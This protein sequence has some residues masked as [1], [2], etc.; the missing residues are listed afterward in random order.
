MRADGI[1]REV[2]CDVEREIHRARLGAVCAA[3]TALIHGGRIGLS[4][5][6]R[7]IG[8][9]S[10]KHGI[11]RIDRLLG[12][13]ALVAELE[14]IYAAIAR[15]V[16]RSVER[17]VI[18]L[19]WTESGHDMYS[20]TAAV[21]LHGR[22][23]TIYSVT[24]PRSQYTA[25]LVENAFLEKLRTFLRSNCRPILVGDAGF[26]TP[27][28]RR[29]Q[30]MGWDFVARVRGRTLVKRVD[31]GAWQ[32]WKH[33]STGSSNRP[34]SLGTYCIARQ[35]AVEAQLVLV[36]RRAPTSAEARRNARARRAARG[37]REACLLATSLSRSAK[38]IAAIYKARMQIE[39][40]FR[41]LK[42]HRFGWGFED[43]G[44]RSTKRV[45][46]QLMLVAVASL[47]VMLVGIAAE[48]KGLQKQFQANTI[49][50]RRVLSLVA[51]GRAVINTVHEQLRVA[52][53]RDHL[54]FVGIP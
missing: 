29:V 25:R 33:L 2:L 54:P 7:A 31:G 35:M 10:H 50:K 48:A 49:R 44:C 19:D 39:L 40:T 13:Q 37:N 42:S 16:L 30:Q 11:K 41:D 47:V 28:M 22:A 21:P 52:K 9:R 1:V 32:H 43:A 26:R 15:Y 17:P 6:G 3:V 8:Q 45:A 36:D 38:D 4:A 5:L 20:L 46:V 27:W 53:L 24:V 51:L 23:I 18:L 14:I 12:N 34:R